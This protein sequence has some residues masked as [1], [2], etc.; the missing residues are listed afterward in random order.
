MALMDME[1]NSHSASQSMVSDKH[2]TDSCNENENNLM[3]RD[4]LLARWLHEPDDKDKLSAPILGRFFS[5]LVESWSG[6][7]E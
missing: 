6:C 3:G 4:P 2:L 5:A 7:L 1:G